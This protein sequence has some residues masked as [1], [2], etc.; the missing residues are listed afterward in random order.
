[1]LP[2]PQLMHSECGRVCQVAF[3]EEGLITGELLYQDKGREDNQR[4]DGRA[5]ANET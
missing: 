5:H 3:G 4:H 2:A 1:M